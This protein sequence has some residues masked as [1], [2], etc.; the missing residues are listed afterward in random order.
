MVSGLKVNISKSMVI[1]VEEVLNIEKI[2]SIIG[3]EVQS[4][5][6][7]YLG[8]SLGAKASLRRFGIR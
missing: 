3:F 6:S 2:S 8:M 4:L 5:P 7:T 1:I